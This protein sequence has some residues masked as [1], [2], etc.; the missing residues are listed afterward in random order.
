DIIR[1]RMEETLEIVKSKIP[2]EDLKAIGYGV[3]LTGGASRMRGLG[4]LASE[5]FGKAAYFPQQPDLSGVQAY[6]K[7]PQY[8]TALGLIRYAQIL[9]EERPGSRFGRIGEL[10]RPFW[11]F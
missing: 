11:P 6:F 7:D 10:L 3:V 1:G 5:V 9:D 2:P 8:S 4:E